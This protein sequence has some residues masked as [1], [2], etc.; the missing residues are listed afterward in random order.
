MGCFNV[1]CSVSKL[2]IGNQRRVALIPLQPADV[3]NGKAHTIKPNSSYLHP[4]EFF[5]PLTFPIFGKYD[6]YGSMEEIEE[7]SNTKAIEKHFGMTIEDFVGLVTCNRPSVNDYYSKHHEVFAENKDIL[8]NHQIEFDE[9]FMRRMG[10]LAVETTEPVEPKPYALAGQPYQVFYV[11]TSREDVMGYEIRNE[12]GK[13]L[14]SNSGHG[15]KKYFLD[16]FFDL[17]GIHLN[18]SRA[19]REK[20]ALFGQLSGMFVDAEIYEELAG[21]GKT[22]ILNAYYDD[23]HTEIQKFAVTKQRIKELEE[24]APPK[25]QEN[26]DNHVEAYLLEMKN[27]FSYFNQDRNQFLRAFKDFK[28]FA[29]IYEEPITAGQLKEMASKYNT[30]HNSMYFTNSLY[31]P[32]MNGTQGGDDEASKQLLEKSLEIVNRRLAEREDD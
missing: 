12:D 24:K 29:E 19:N 32:A 2:S 26:A 28:L 22:N 10:L 31:L 8:R 17:T 5:N 15:V 20:A 1:A 27:P 16:D 3:W 23:L 13:V 30:F 11:P 18:V 6:D 21:D 4:N 9:K 7:N 14:K 25:T